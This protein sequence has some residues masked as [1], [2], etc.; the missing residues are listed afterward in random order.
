MLGLSRA[1]SRFIH[2]LDRNTVTMVGLLLGALTGFADYAAGADISLAF[3]YLVPV[4]FVA[5]YADLSRG[6][7][8]ALLCTLLWHGVNMLL[9][10]APPSLQLAFIDLSTHLGFFLI[11]A[12]LLARQRA[13]LDRERR[14]SRTDFLTGALNRRAFIELTSNEIERARRHHHPFTISYFDLDNFKTVNDE[15]GHAAGDAVLCRIVCIAR[16]NLRTIDSIA[17]LGG[18][19]FALLFPETDRIAA[20]AVVDKIFRLVQNEMDERAWPI[21]LSVGVLTCDQPP[22]SVEA[23]LRAVDKLMYKV[24]L[25]GKNAVLYENLVSESSGMEPHR[26]A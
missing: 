21:T 17:R 10:I 25:A 22:H 12:T 24:K 18:D 19:E 6:G 20:Q 9:G 2:R 15:L 5:W 11:V 3:F 1:I 23:M 14:A 4:A 16:Q 8:M 7:L 26:A 13:L